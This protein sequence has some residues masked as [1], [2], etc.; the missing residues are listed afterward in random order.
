MTQNRYPNQIR[1]NLKQ[2]QIQNTNETPEKN[3]QYEIDMNNKEHNETDFFFFR[4]NF[5]FFFVDV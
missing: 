5:F 4:A 2:S 1:I 3:T